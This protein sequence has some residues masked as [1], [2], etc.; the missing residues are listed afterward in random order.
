MR[1]TEE[2]AMD[3]TPDFA[4]LAEQ[5]L[6]EAREIAANG[7]HDAQTLLRHDAQGKVFIR[8]G[9]IT[10]D[11]TR[12]TGTGTTPTPAEML[13]S[14]PEAEDVSTEAEREAFELTTLL[15]DLDPS[16]TAA[17]Y[18]VQPCTIFHRSGPV[19]GKTVATFNTETH[20]IYELWEWDSQD[21][22]H[23]RYTAMTEVVMVHL[24]DG[25][26]FARHWDGT[27]FRVEQ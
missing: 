25:T 4:K 5:W 14:E 16:E 12:A 24:N 7:P 19:H 17:H 3:I 21:W 8:H 9:W 22:L 10:P 2:G 27:W 26:K 11:G 20:Q 1:V 18:T 13:S 6:E 15:D 23:R